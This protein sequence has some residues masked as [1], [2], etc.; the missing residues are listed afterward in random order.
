MSIN[1][2]INSYYQYSPMSML[3]HVLFFSFI[4][5]FVF[6][7]MNKPERMP[8]S[9][10]A[11][12]TDIANNIIS[13]NKLDSDPEI[14]KKEIATFWKNKNGTFIGASYYKMT[15]ALFKKTKV[16]FMDI[17]S[18]FRPIYFI[19]DDQASYPKIFKFLEL[20][21]SSDAAPEFADIEKEITGWVTKYKSY[22]QDMENL[23][24]EYATLSSYVSKLRELKKD[25]SA[26]FPYEI[27]I[28]LISEGKNQTYKDYI[29]SNE[30][31]ENLILKF[32]GKMK[33]LKGTSYFRLGVVDQREF[34]QALL[35]ERLKALESEI[36]THLASHPEQEDLFKELLTD[37]IKINRDPAFAPTLKYLTKLEFTEMNAEY[38][39]LFKTGSVDLKKVDEF[40]K[41]VIENLS[42]RYQQK[43]GINAVKNW[44]T[45]MKAS[46]M[47]IIVGGVG[48]LGTGTGAIAL[49]FWNYLNYDK[50]SQ[51]NI[52]NAKD[53]D[54]F[55]ENLKKYLKSE[56]SMDEI[57]RL[58]KKNDNEMTLKNYNP[59]KKKDVELV[60]LV[61]GII[62][63]RRKF[64]HEEK[65]LEDLET[66]L[67]TAIENVRTQGN[68]EEVKPPENTD[69]PNDKPA[70]KK[71]D[72]ADD[73]PAKP[74]KPTKPDSKKPKPATN[75][76]KPSMPVIKIP[77]RPV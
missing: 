2:K 8:A 27:Q 42:P 44:V 71:D 60:E 49:R 47:G 36:R 75:N 62:A 45:Q 63:E 58:E 3:K 64:V 59:K 33:K 6:F 4:F 57:I 48:A 7:E 37:L 56:F 23:I 15:K 40:S 22:T 68:P 21:S 38:N 41:K 65:L 10:Q 28:N 43:L 30:D 39:D 66:N 70:D 72:S 67:T 17:N 29:G 9:P 53:E 46:R 52:I 77:V 76:G 11:T 69:K 13:S 24:T 1:K 31:L 32:K 5:S 73:K 61:N 54:T 51:Y 55:N 34:E 16:L 19:E 35:T 50:D 14:A 74:A 18:N 25:K 12:C 20:K 26:V